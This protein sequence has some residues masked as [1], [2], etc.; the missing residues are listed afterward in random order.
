MISDT[1]PLFNDASVYVSDVDFSE[2]TA[3]EPL[4]RKSVMW[5]PQA[6]LRA[7]A[8]VAIGGVLTMAVAQVSLSK[9]F[10]YAR[11]VRNAPWSQ[12]PLVPDSV[13]ASAAAKANL[14]IHV[15]H[16]EGDLEHPDVD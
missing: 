11:A 9:Q 1:T 12:S 3:A 10:V 4:T 15:P 6:V 13:L 16:N 5:V 14:F 2:N 8:T 7:A